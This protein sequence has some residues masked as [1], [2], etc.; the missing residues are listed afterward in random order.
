MIRDYT[1]N[2]IYRNL[3][4]IYLLS[5]I[6]LF[7]SILSFIPIIILNITD[8]FFQEIGL[9]NSFFM[10][11]FLLIFPISVLRASQKAGKKTYGAYYH[12]E[13]RSNNDFNEMLIMGIS[14]LYSHFIY[15]IH[16]LLSIIFNRES[17]NVYVWGIICA[18]L[19]IPHLSLYISSIFAFVNCGLIKHEWES[20]PPKFYEELKKEKSQA[21]IEKIEKDIYDKLVKLV[22]KCGLKFLIKYYSKIKDTFTKDIEI[23]EY[24]SEKEKEIRIKA[25]R[26]ILNLHVPKDV[27]IKFINKYSSSL[28]QEEIYQAI[29]MIEE[30]TI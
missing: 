17:D 26:E 7:L 25:V 20:D 4:I 21:K 12:L 14:P 2:N 22:E 5:V 23:T 3:N 13:S 1:N 15:I 19:F 27:M 11:F 30:I 6:S 28:T 29:V 8:D 10:C 16:L 18:T 24:Y 9:L